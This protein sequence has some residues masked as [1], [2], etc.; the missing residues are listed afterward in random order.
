MRGNVPLDMCVSRRLRAA[1]APALSHK[2]RIYPP[3]EKL[4]HWVSTDRLMKALIKLPG[5]AGWSESSMGVHVLRYTVAYCS[6]VIASQG[7][8]F[9]FLYEPVQSSRKHIFREFFLFYHEIVCCVHQLESPFYGPKDIR[10]IEVRLY[11]TCMYREDL[12]GLVTFGRFFAIFN[13][14]GNL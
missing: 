10:S 7:L 2:R 8:H 4:S 1:C 11:M 14:G 3:I 5:Y 12:R 6:S 9:I 13:R